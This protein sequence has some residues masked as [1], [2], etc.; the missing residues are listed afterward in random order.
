MRILVTGGFG[1]VGTVVVNECLKRGHQVTVFEVR[2]RHTETMSRQLRSRGIGTILG[3]L[4]RPDEV[5]Q[6]VLGQ[7]SVIHLAAVLPP[8]SES[9]PSLCREVNVGGTDNL[10]RA[11][12][13]S[14][15]KPT[16]VA[17]S[18]ASVM[19][20]TQDHRPPVR[21]ADPVSPTDA[22]SRSKVEVEA[23]VTTSSL[24]SCILRLAAVLPTSVNYRSLSSMT[25][26]IFDMPLDARCEVVIDLDVAYALVSAAEGLAGSSALAGTIGFVAGG[27]RQG[28]QLTTREL[29]SLL[30]SSVGLRSPDESLFTPDLNSYYLDWYD[31]E[32]IESFLQFQR[33]SVQEWRATILGMTRFLRPFLPLLRDGIA[34]WLERQSPRFRSVAAGYKS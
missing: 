15:R 13:S 17:V 31:T 12:E 20:P 33:H 18:S 7:D 34:A 5:A 10:I 27:R 2:N 6:A 32:T 8:V 3:D 29:V 26:L 16:L 21:P 1:N 4:R 19:G 28:C 11:M 14:R 30:F 24:R 22:Y 25:K 9:N 23:L